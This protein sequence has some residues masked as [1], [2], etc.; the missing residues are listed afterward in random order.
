[1]TESNYGNPLFDT[2]ADQIPR[3]AVAANAL[4]SDCSDGAM[5]IDAGEVGK[6]M[7]INK[8]ASCQSNSI[9]VYFTPYSMGEVFL[10][11]E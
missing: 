2:L 7:Y 5:I 9:L 3:V 6:E 8:T 1:V 4:Y 10:D 11:L